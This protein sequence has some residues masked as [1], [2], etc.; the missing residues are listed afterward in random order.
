[1]S[2]N[3][4]HC[5]KLIPAADVNVQGNVAFCRAC[6]TVNKLSELADS[7]VLGD[8]D[9][10]RPPSGVTYGPKGA[11]AEIV[12]SHRSIG[13]A[14][15]T[16]LFA[17]FWNGILSVFIGVALLSTMKLMH[18]PRPNQLA[19]PQFDGDL[20]LWGTIGLW[21][22]LLPFIAVGLFLLATFV[23]AIAGR[24]EIRIQP[25]ECTLFSGVGAVGWRRRFNPANVT[26]V[27]VEDLRWRDGDGDSRRSTMIVL[28]METGKPLKFGSGFKPEQ[29][30]F[31]AAVMKKLLSP[32]V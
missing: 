2:V 12:L 5:N 28:E 26:Q 11:G 31:V 25:G 21:I 14:I 19:G 32:R 20:G 24:T 8:V 9:T 29:R 27:R 3:C 10:S 7:A 17:L 13:S 30:N 22:F 18:L 16:L 15:G 6:N 23:M 4:A 1:M